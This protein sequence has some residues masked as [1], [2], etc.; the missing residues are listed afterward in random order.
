MHL[1]QMNERFR[2]MGPID[3]TFVIDEWYTEEGFYRK[4][5]KRRNNKKCLIFTRIN[6]H[7]EIFTNLFYTSLTPHGV[8]GLDAY[9]ELYNDMQ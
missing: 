3:D 8:H 5:Q 7:N 9:I 6:V 4:N 2:G 1:A